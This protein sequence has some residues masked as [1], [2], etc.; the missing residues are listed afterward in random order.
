MIVPMKKIALIALCSEAQE[1]VERLQQMG[2]LHVQQQHYQDLSEHVVIA[3]MHERIED[4]KTCIYYLEDLKNEKLEGAASARKLSVDEMIERIERIDHIDLE[5]QN[6]GKVLDDFE[7]F[8]DFDPRQIQHLA[9]KG[10]HVR[11]Y[12]SNRGALPAIPEHAAMVTLKEI[13]DELYYAVVSDRPFQLDL[14][15]MS[16][17]EKPTTELKDALQGLREERQAIRRELAAQARFIPE[18]RNELLG[19]HD[20][21]ALEETRERLGK[22]GELCWIIGYCPTKH[23]PAVEEAAKTYGWGLRI[24]DPDGHDEVP[25]LIEN[26][27]WLRPVETVFNFIETYPGYRERDASPPFYFF[28]S[29][30]YAMLIG[31]VGYGMIF[32]AI[33]A[34]VHIRFGD[35]IPKQP[36][37]LFYVF[38]IATVIWGVL[39]GSWFGIRLSPDNPLMK[40]AVID[41]DNTQLMMIICFVIG[42]I[43]LSIAHLW[44][45]VCMINSKKAIAEIGWLMALWTAFFL[46]M[47]VIAG[48]EYPSFMTWVGLAGIAMALIF[49]GDLTNV[50]GAFQFPFK[51]IGCFADIA[52]YLRLFAVG[53]AAVALARVFN[54]MAVEMGWNGVLATFG[55][56]VILLV[57]HSL[58][59]V[60]GPLSVLVH[61]LRLNLLEFSGHMGQ[62]WTGFKY[63]PFR[64]H[65][66]TNDQTR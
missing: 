48:V 24:T 20:E 56:A 60:L 38:N 64:C 42:A 12:R 13:G 15:A 55:T 41:T 2:V 37:I 18:L 46:A 49:S 4:I 54:G 26:P 58:N 57:G 3:R 5:N 44:N 28:L 39:T 51:V 34:G 50:A 45:M 11:L 10:V 7:P 19:V 62:E 31:D 29:L 63:D 53:S 43:H 9:E 23:L 33:C 40:L 36:L 32:L 8:G 52:S 66:T 61:G 59:L 6:I 21:L 27:G 30:F 14:P 47:N 17:P 35:R 16:L 1:T 25:T 65:R 22:H